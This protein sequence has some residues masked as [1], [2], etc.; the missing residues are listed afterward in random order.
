MKQKN[1]NNQPLV[2]VLII[3]YNSSSFILE[4]LESIKAQT[5][6]NLELIISDDSSSDR[7]VEICEKW[8]DKNKHRFVRTEL[9]TSEKN[10]GVSA[11]ANR[12]LYASKGLW[13]KGIAGDDILHEDCINELIGFIITQPYDIRI[14]STDI[15]KFS[16]DPGNNSKTEKNPFKWFC[17]MDCSPND[18]YEMLLRANR[19][20]AAS[21]I[22]RRDLLLSVDG[23]DE[24]FRLMEDW[25]LWIKFT[26]AG[27]KI[28]HIN[29]ALVYYR[30]HESNLSQTTNQRYVYHP[31]N[32]IS[33]DFREKVILK[34][35]PLIESLALKL[36]IQSM[37]ICFNLGN[38]KK[39]L[40]VMFIYFFAKILNPFHNYLR[41]LNIL[42][43]EYRYNKYL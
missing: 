14:L 13:I 1:N 33:M 3:T 29:K 20:F 23:Y 11:N 35:L 2:S 43:I 37:K 36:E 6:Q 34:R 28:Y 31:F 39:N 5:Y 38:N 15:M 26:S 30:L 24:R 17:S 21:V 9:I 12:G 16:G 18:Q 19:V 8:I 32:K 10:T 25:P 42:G 22:I 27:H 4:T 7:T 40:F 41:L